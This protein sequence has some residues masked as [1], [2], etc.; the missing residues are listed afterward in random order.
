[1]IL[2]W[3]QS[4]AILLVPLVG[5]AIMA[6][7]IARN[8]LHPILGN[9]DIALIL[10]PLNDNKGRTRNYMIC[11]RIEINPKK[12]AFRI[13]KKDEGFTYRVDDSMVAFIQ[14]THRVFYYL[15]K[16]AYPIPYF[17]GAPG[18]NTSSKGMDLFVAQRLWQQAVA[19]TQKLNF[20]LPAIMLVMCILAGVGVGGIAT[21]LYL[22][23]VAHVIGQGTVTVTMG[24][25]GGITGTYTG[26]LT[27]TS[28]STS[29]SLLQ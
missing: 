17:V 1:M 27:S 19:A 20:T 22:S 25:N 3:L 6:L 9:F 29:H 13:G 7:V 8:L 2:D 5:D 28:N 26:L 16:K 14:R 23:Q 24:S 12:E 18:R 10:R 15:E 11:G 21:Y 4:N